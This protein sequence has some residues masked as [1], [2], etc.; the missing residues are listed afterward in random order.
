[1]FWLFW[2]IPSKDKSKMKEPT[3]QLRLLTDEQFVPKSWNTTEELV[4]F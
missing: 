3:W 2:S 1:M 4:N